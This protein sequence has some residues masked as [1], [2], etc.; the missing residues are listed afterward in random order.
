LSKIR[1]FAQLFLE[2]LVLG[3]QIFEHLLLFL[4]DPASEYGQQHLP[5]MKHEAHGAIGRRSA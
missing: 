5:G 2:H 1:F 4:V 3:T